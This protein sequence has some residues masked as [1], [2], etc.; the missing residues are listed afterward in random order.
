MNAE[1]L[2]SFLQCYGQQARCISFESPA[3]WEYRS[4]L[5]SVRNLHVETL[6]IEHRYG[7]EAFWKS[8][9]SEEAGYESEDSE[10]LDLEEFPKKLAKTVKFHPPSFQVALERYWLKHPEGQSGR[11]E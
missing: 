2:Y 3:D 1:N 5:E 9:N 10:T 8:I 4:A 6:E 7:E 11:D